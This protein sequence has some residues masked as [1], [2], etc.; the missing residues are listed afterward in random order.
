MLLNPVSLLSFDPPI[1]NPDFRRAQAS[2][3]RRSVSKRPSTGS[4]LKFPNSKTMD[5]HSRLRALSAFFA[6]AKNFTLGCSDPGSPRCCARVAVALPA[7]SQHLLT[8]AILPEDLLEPDANLTV[9]K[10]YPLSRTAPS[11]I[12]IAMRFSARPRSHPQTHRTYAS[13]SP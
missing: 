6:P 2:R 12:L 10:Q 5:N 3:P 1:P 8:N 13:R 7:L 11:H 9:L 4:T